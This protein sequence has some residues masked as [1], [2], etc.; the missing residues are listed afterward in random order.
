MIDT[1]SRVGLL[2]QIQVRD[3]LARPAYVIAAVD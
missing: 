3:C 1:E 2:A